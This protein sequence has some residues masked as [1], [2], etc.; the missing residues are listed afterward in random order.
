MADKFTEALEELKDALT[1]GED[2]EEALGNISADHELKRDALYNRATTMWGDLAKYQT[3]R[4]SEAPLQ[5]RLS[6]A[7]M[8]R[9]KMRRI[10][11]KRVNGEK[12]TKEEAEFD[13]W[14]F[15]NNDILT[16]DRELVNKI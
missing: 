3:K 6:I 9:A 13:H 12:L 5:D 4:V 11:I 15:W 16:E 10:L 8:R 7:I 1:N 2:L 14:Y